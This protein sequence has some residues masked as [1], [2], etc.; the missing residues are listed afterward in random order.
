MTSLNP[1]QPHYEFTLIDRS[2]SLPPAL[3]TPTGKARRRQFHGGWGGVGRGGAERGW[4]CRG[5]FESRSVAMASK[6]LERGSSRKISKKLLAL[7]KGRWGTGKRRPISGSEIGQPSGCL[8]VSRLKR[9][10][11]KFED[12]PRISGQACVSERA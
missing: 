10:A 11:D 3:P 7:K 9:R 6:R 5:R 12:I 2:E 1:K 8:L 4:G